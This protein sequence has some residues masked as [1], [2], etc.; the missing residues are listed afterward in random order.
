VQ[1]QIVGT[2][3]VDV[4]EKPTFEALWLLYPKKVARFD[5]HKAW[6]RLSESDRLSAIVGLV[7][8]RQVWVRRGEM[9]FVPHCATWLNGHRWEDE[10]P[11]QWTQGAAHASHA[12]AVIPESGARTEMP[13]HVR[14]ALAK[15]RKP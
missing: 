7:A 2:A 15:L 12:T 10:L 3:V 8:W 11:E 5:A 14:A 4:D 6:N 9:Q 1:L 13:A